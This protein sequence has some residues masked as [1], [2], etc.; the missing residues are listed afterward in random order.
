[1][2]RREIRQVATE[3]F[4]EV[5]EGRSTDDVV[6]DDRLN[7]RFIKCCRRSL[8][9]TDEFDLNWGLLGLR[10]SSELGP[11]V[12]RTARQRHDD[13]VHAAEFAAR[14][15]EDRYRLTVDRVL[16]TPQYREEF[17][18]VALR[19]APNI[20]PYLLRKAALKLRKGRQL[21]PELIKRVADWG[22]CV[23]R[24][25]AKELQEDPARIPRQPGIYVFSDST[26]YLYIGQASNLQT[27]VAKHLDHSDRKALAR[28]LWE[29][30]VEDLVVELHVFASTSNGRLAAHRRAYEA[31]LIQA[32]KPRFNIQV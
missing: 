21:R 14:H 13:Y 22:K 7:Q 12:T 32:R 6:I 11:V 28:Y 20:A 18:R 19:L 8:P 10:K 27:R 1:M 2:R 5:H 25:D 26:S 9:D 24:F 31:N 29:Q 3:A 23:L 30:G 16:C 15:L 4:F 17:D